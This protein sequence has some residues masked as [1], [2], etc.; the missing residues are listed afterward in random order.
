[1]K[2]VTDCVSME[3]MMSRGFGLLF[4]SFLLAS[5]IFSACTP[6]GE[7]ILG[8]QE[9]LSDQVDAT[10][11]GA[12]FAY[13]VAVDTI[14]YNSCTNLTGNPAN[15]IHGFKIG[16]S[17]GYASQTTN[18]IKA[19]LKL[20]SEFLQYVGQTF[21]PAYP[22]P[23]ITPTQILNILKNSDNNANA[24]LQ[25]AIRRK[26]DLIAIPDYINLTN[27]VATKNYDVVL[28]DQLLH[29]G[30]VGYNLTNTIQYSTS[31]IATYE[32]N[33]IMSLSNES[34]ALPIE[35]ALKFNAAIDTSI[36]AP[37]PVAGDL[38]N[39]G[40]A[41]AYGQFIRDNFN[42]A[43]DSTG[44]VSDRY[45]LA[46]TFG[47]NEDVVLG[48]DATED[49]YHLNYLIRPTDS[50]SSGDL[51]KAYGKGFAL[52]FSSPNTNYTNW[53]STKLTSVKELDLTT[54]QPVTGGVSWTC[55][56]YLIMKQEHWNN[57]KLIPVNNADNTLV[58]PSCSPMMAEDLTDTTI[59]SGSTIG[60][61]QLRREKIQRLRR[62]Y[63]EIYWNV[64]LYIPGG[65]R[66]TY[67]LPARNTLNQLCIAPKLS[68]DTCYLPTSYVIASSPLTEVGVQYDTTK[69][70]YTTAIGPKNDVNRRKGRC[71][72]FASVCVRN[73]SY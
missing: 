18:G 56:N 3:C 22:S 17:E 45:L 23:T 52:K 62:H 42:K 30:F 44:N 2:K 19:G 24:Y 67:V 21:T 37:T 41:E 58:E 47:G 11:K 57:N 13:D 4:F 32:G 51:T 39:Y 69:D 28:F 34:T 55:E 36:T 71:A 25:F 7:G 9:S 38:E 60:L 15:N 53:V 20:R 54:G 50:S 61:G 73:S 29:D 43:Y 63:P 31:G 64:G 26:S 59:V 5:S 8:S 12:P 6:Q 16:A 10:I 70:C 66:S 14:S 35:A 46:A 48:T 68:T 1:M 49:N 72:Q 27:K 40:Y 65:A 33:R